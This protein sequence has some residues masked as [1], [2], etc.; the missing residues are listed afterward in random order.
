MIKTIGKEE[1]KVCTDLSIDGADSENPS[2]RL[3]PSAA[4]VTSDIYS[5]SFILS[6]GKRRINSMEAITRGV[7]S[8]LLAYSVHYGILKA[9]SSYCIPDGTWG[10]LQGL[11]SAGS[12]VCQS[13]LNIGAQTQISYSSFVLVAVSRVFVDMI[14]VKKE[15]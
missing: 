12:P 7:V 3:R 6:K 5:M 9:Y 10:F 14:P 1:Y 4:F 2:V 11:L 13:M 15:E 8:G